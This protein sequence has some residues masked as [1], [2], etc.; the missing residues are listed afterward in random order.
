MSALLN[1][2][3]LRDYLLPLLDILLLA[4][5]I[6]RSY[7]ILV[8]TRA[9][10]LIKGALVIGLIY[11]VAYALTLNTLRWVLNLLVPGLVIGMAII[12]QPELRRI[13]TRIG[14]DPWFRLRP[15]VRTHHLEAVLNAAG[16]LAERRCG[17]LIVFT[18]NI[19]LNTI[20]ETGTHLNADLSSSLLL[21]L[22]SPSTPLHD[23]AVIISEDRVVAAGCLLPLSDRP[24]IQL[25]YGTRHRAALGLV[26]ETDAV[27]LVV[28][29]ETGAISLA[30]DSNLH[31]DLQA[32]EIT[33]RLKRLLGLEGEKQEGGRLEA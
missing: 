17:C 23:G 12:F 18:R 26:E 8:Q 24:D 6:Y 10:Q 13:F 4:Y 19:G 30:H 9:V 3:L 27:V 16:M 32:S 28:S 15:R 1:Y 29:E 2:W 25:S 21:S 20:I 33:R 22:F 7:R 5:L 14:Q 11:L 31:Y